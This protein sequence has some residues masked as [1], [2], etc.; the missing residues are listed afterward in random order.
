MSDTSDR[1]EI[2][3]LL[4]RHQIAIDLRDTTAYADLFAP[5]GE[6]ESP[7]GTARGTEAIQE[8]TRGL[9]EQ[10]FTE[11]KRHLTG[12]MTVEVNGDEAQALSYW[13]VAETRE[14]PGVYSTGTYT[15]RLRRIDGRWKILHRKQE[16]DPNWPGGDP[17][18]GTS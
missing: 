10:G 6:F 14:A 3:E 2:T 7:F 4:N 9:H 1:F 13:W 17:A 15:D 12:P 18:A 11:G 5:D 16:I 8:M